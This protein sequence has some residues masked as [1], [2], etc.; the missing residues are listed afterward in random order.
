MAVAVRY[1]KYGPYRQQW[2]RRPECRT[3]HINRLHSNS[4]GY[5]YKTPQASI[6]LACGNEA[7]QLEVARLASYISESGPLSD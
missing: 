6:V 5:H 7:I 4:K 1:G 2:K 3:G